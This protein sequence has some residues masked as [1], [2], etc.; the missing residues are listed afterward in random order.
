[1]EARRANRPVSFPYMRDKH[2][3]TADIIHQWDEES[4]YRFM[5]L[6]D[7]RP[8]AMVEGAG[9]RTSDDVATAVWELQ[10]E[11][12]ESLSVVR[13]PE[14]NAPATIDMTGD[15]TVGLPPDHGAIL[16]IPQ[17]DTERDVDVPV[18]ATMYVMQGQ[19]P[20]PADQIVQHPN[21]RVENITE[22]T[23]PAFGGLRTFSVTIHTLSANGTAQRHTLTYPPQEFQ[24]FPNSDR[25]PHG[26]VFAH[27]E[28]DY[29]ILHN[30]LWRAIPSEV[31]DDIDFSSYIQLAPNVWLPTRDT[32]AVLREDGGPVSDPVDSRPSVVRE[33]YPDGAN[34]HGLG[35]GQTKGENYRCA[36]CQG[37]K[38]V[39]HYINCA[40]HPLG[41]ADDS[42][43]SDYEPK[44]QETDLWSDVPDS[45]G[46]VDSIQIPDAYYDERGRCYDCFDELPPIA[47]ASHGDRV[48]VFGV[49]YV[50]SCGQWAE[51][52]GTDV[53]SLR[54]AAAPP[55]PREGQMFEHGGTVYRWNEDT[56]THAEGK[57]ILRESGVQPLP[58]DSFL[59]S[60]G[61]SLDGQI[62]PFVD[63]S[64]AE[65]EGTRWRLVGQVWRPLPIGSIMYWNGEM[66][67][68]NGTEFIP[69]YGDLSPLTN[70]PND[71][72]GPGVQVNSIY[73]CG[74]D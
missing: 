74:N 50:F 36:M 57:Y 59:A 41:P 31:F 39:E 38:H 7:V 49:L 53:D 37:C 13:L 35:I 63:G 46:T 8:G 23:D 2:Q 71:G 69:V 72:P 30:Q 21:I 32:P 54:A 26:T 4:P 19:D 6:V 52:T 65:Y 42:N 27:P 70:S 20:P 62:T 68:W 18:G 33:A 12:R 73:Y 55:S 22:T 29:Y 60:G 5:L 48:V 40:M 56:W 43:C 34:Y 67:M 11:L 17:A 66:H 3:F 14:S 47:D 16:S 64:I 45:I 61:Y 25:S 58:S 44:A 9:Y 10:T 28:G 51:V 15:L 24:D 1:M